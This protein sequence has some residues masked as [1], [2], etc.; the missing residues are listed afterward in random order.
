MQT[1]A[2]HSVHFGAASMHLAYAR[3]LPS[4]IA[5][6]TLVKRGRAM[7]IEIETNES[8]REPEVIVR[9]AV[10]DDHIASIVAGLRMHD[11][12]MT[13]DV[14]GEMRIVAVGE[15]LYVES[16]DGRSFAYTGDA[17]LEMPLRLCELEERLVNAG[18]VKVARSCLVNLCRIAGLRPYVGGRLL[19]RLD[20]DEEIVISR[21][22]AGEIRKRLDA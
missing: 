14:D 19:A 20:N 5:P 16:I 1:A 3:P 15:I 9:C 10:V 11:R 17:V 7:K 22:Y 6:Y 12:K 2:H 4:R 8:L 18:F 13:G 21:K